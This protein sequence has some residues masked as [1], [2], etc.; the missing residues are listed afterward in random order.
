MG[1]ED[2]GRRVLIAAHRGTAGG[3]IPCNTLVSYE[4]A[5]HDGADIIELDVAKS[6]DGK[7]FC[8]H[9][10]ME[11]VM[12]ADPTPIAELPA[13]QAAVRYLRNQ[14]LE[15]TVYTAPNLD[16]AFEMLK[17]RC[18]VAVDKFW[19]AMPEISQCIRRHGM[20]EQVLC[21]IPDKQKYYV[22]CSEL[23]PDLPVLP[24]IRTQDRST[25]AP[26]AKGVRIAGIEVLFEREDE[27]VA[28]PEYIERQHRLGRLLW[29]NPIVY[30]RDAILTAGHT[31]DAAVA[32]NRDLGWGWLVDRGFDI[33]QTD[34]TAQLR[35]YLSEQ[36]PLG[37]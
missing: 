9:P 13:E 21:K 35:R 14:D 16:E 25:D 10:G 32:G 4:L 29:V 34:F 27:A 23:A 5:L 11:P 15:E 12:Y 36:Y 1:K 17:N 20:Q 18:L 22:N 6:L 7:L 19:M 30:K 24:V 26:Y 37:L 8:F 33:L 31:D 3:N 28:S 2:S